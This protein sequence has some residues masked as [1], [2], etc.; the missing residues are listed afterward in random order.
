MRTNSIY[1]QKEAG[2][3]LGLQKDVSGKHFCSPSYGVR[4]IEMVEI[5]ARQET[6]LST[7][8]DDKEKLI[9]KLKDEI[10]NLHKEIQNKTIGDFDNGDTTRNS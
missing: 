7:I 9:L 6:R 10:I 5:L 2:E 8:I 3:Y 1:V 4:A